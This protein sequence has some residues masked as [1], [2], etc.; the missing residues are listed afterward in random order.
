MHSWIYLC[1][2][3]EQLPKGILLSLAFSGK[4]QCLLR[5]DSCISWYYTAHSPWYRTVLRGIG[6]QLRPSDFS[7][8][9]RNTRSK[10]FFPPMAPMSAPI[11]R[12]WRWVM[13]RGIN[14]MIR[15][16][17]ESSRAPGSLPRERKTNTSA[18]SNNSLPLLARLFIWN[19]FVRAV[20]TTC[21]FI[22]KPHKTIHTFKLCWKIHFSLWKHVL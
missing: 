2:F 17:R 14:Q 19:N 11:C 4:F 10:T 16:T 8:P 9:N 18:R 12:D 3:K 6:F 22:K 15:T 5:P 20:F 13:D 21:T 7:H 1:H